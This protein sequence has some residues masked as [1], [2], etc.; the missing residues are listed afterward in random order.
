MKQEEIRLGKVIR[1]RGTDKIYYI[2]SWEEG[3]VNLKNP[4]TDEPKKVLTYTLLR[5]YNVLSEGEINM[6]GL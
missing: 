1:Q 3:W 6:L 4:W 2:A 5:W